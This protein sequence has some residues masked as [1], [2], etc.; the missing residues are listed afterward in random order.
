[1][2]TL[3][4]YRKVEPNIWAVL[5]NCKPIGIVSW[6]NQIYGWAFYT[7][8]FTSEIPAHTRNAAVTQWPGL[9]ALAV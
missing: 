7:Q 6:K 5:I 2:E 9:K 3:L 8:G 1:M 4:R